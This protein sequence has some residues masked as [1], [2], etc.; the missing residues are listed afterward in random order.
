MSLFISDA[1]AAATAPAA[2]ANA[3]PPSIINTVLFIAIFFGVFYFL[4]IRPQAKKQKELRAM[5]SNLSKGDEIVTSSGI[6]GK[7]KEITDDFMVV[8]IADNTNIK[9]QK[10]AV[11]MVLPQG[12]IK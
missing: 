5:L 4:F 12:T 7:I 8:E 1:L 2:N 11:S 10:N 6:L 9:L 3:H